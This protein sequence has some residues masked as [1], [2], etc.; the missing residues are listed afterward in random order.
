MTQPEPPEEDRSIEAL[1]ATE[2]S[3][4]TSLLCLA[5]LA[6]LFVLVRWVNSD[7][8]FYLQTQGVIWISAGLAG[9]LLLASY[10][11]IKRYILPDA[12]TLPLIIAGLGVHFA[13]TGLWRDSLFGAALGYGMFAALSWAWLTYRGKHALGLGDAKLLAAGGAFCTVWAVPLIIMVGAM[14]A[15][16]FIL[17]H[18]IF[19]NHNGLSIVPFGPF[20]ALGIWFAWV[21]PSLYLV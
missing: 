11:D 20:L 9:A 21:W 13:W 19:H 5:V 12:I 1:L 7:T 2:R 8:P 3:V 4:R 16:V 10:T 6:G 14:S 17:L 18:R 15:L